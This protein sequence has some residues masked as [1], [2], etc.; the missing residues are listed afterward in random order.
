MTEIGKTDRRQTTERQQKAVADR[1]GTVVVPDCRD[2]HS[3]TE[4]SEAWLEVES[5]VRFPQAG[6]VAVGARWVQQL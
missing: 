2:W 1:N 6:A 5:I 3:L 4:P